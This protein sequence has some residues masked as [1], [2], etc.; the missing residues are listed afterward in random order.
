MSH[1]KALQESMPDIPIELVDI[2]NE[3]SYQIFPTEFYYQLIYSILKIDM[4][5]ILKLYNGFP[6]IPNIDEKIQQIDNYI[7]QIL[8]IIKQNMTLIYKLR[9]K[10][11]DLWYDDI[12]EPTKSILFNF[13]NNIRKLFDFSLNDFSSKTLYLFYEYR[14]YLGD[15]NKL[16]NL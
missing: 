4:K 12:K 15:L 3:Y 2:I 11:S 16:F 8:P 13:E 1:K 5:S 6:P 7:L 14:R 10:R 9:R